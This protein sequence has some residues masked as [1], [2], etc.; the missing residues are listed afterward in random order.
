MH[1]PSCSSRSIRLV[2]LSTSVTSPTLPNHSQAAVSSVIAPLSLPSVQIDPTPKPLSYKPPTPNGPHRAPD[3]LNM[4]T[5]SRPPSAERRV[6]IYPSIQHRPRMPQVSTKVAGLWHFDAHHRTLP[7][8]AF[9]ASGADSDLLS[10]L[11]GALSSLGSHRIC[12]LQWRTSR[13]LWLPVT[14]V[15]Q[16]LLPLHCVAQAQ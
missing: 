9:S 15:L 2:N 6:T 16:T 11:S 13:H 14:P 12:A 7:L 8:C 10:Q 1:N 3:R 5:F 4:S